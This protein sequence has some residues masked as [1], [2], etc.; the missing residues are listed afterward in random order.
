MV[1]KNLENIFQV[2]TFQ[3][4]WN[5][6]L[7]VYVKIRFLFSVHNKCQDIKFDLEKC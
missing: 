1:Q 6:G 4:Y 2:T 7:F 3:N 5:T